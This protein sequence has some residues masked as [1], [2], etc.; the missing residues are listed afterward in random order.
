[1]K[2]FPKIRLNA[3]SDG[4]ALNRLGVRSRSG[5]KGG[6]GLGTSS[7]ETERACS[8]ER[9]GL[10][11]GSGVGTSSGETERA[12]GTAPAGLKERSVARACKTARFSVKACSSGTEPFGLKERAGL[13]TRSGVRTGSGGTEHAV[14]CACKTARFSVKACS[15][16]TEPFGLKERAR[17][18]IRTGLRTG[19]GVGTS[20]GETA[21]A[22]STERSGL[23]TGSAVRT[24][25]GLRTRSGVSLLISIVLVAIVTV[26]ALGVSNL[27][28]S[29]LRQTANVNRSNQAFFAA[30]GALEEGLLQNQTQGA[31]YTSPATDVTLCDATQTGADCP[32]A[33]VAIQGTVPTALK[34]EYSGTYNGMYSIPTPG[35]GTAGNDCSPLKAYYNK[36]YVFPEGSSSG[37][38]TYAPWEHP[39][40]WNKLRVG[41]SVA[42]PLYTV[43]AGDSG[44]NC[45]FD[46]YLG[47]KVCNPVNLGLTNLILRVRTPCMDGSE[48]CPASERYDLQYNAGDPYYGG[49]D[50]VVAW[51]ITATSLDHKTTYTLKPRTDSVIGYPHNTRGPMNTEI[52]EGLIKTAR[53]S[54][55]DPFRIFK[56]TSPGKDLFGVSGSLINF[57]TNAVTFLRTNLDI[58]N[59]PVLKLTLVHSLDAFSGN[60]SVPYLEY[61][62]LTNSSILPPTDTSQTI[63]AEGVSG[64]FK[65]VLEVKQPQES[66]LL[67]YVIQQ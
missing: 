27:V 13:R 65:Q 11:T 41:E 62:L 23:R 9:T 47:Y 4:M 19:S 51:Q 39:C 20:S 12:G 3:P 64:T 43:A 22:C 56:E 15:S 7:G 67:E 46:S 35:T 18:E 44:S 1:M 61:Q 2:T 30:E 34:Y 29:T 40:N 38:Q 66:G 49:D 59:Q 24:G 8:T 36:A 14:A 50:T 5:V 57:L 63:T 26:F 25:A 28:F 55:S 53:L 45:P 21:R 32:T 10:R 52:S 37:Q 54:T 6:D 48:F 58:I 31:G 42:I 33:T 60:T 17:L 16:G